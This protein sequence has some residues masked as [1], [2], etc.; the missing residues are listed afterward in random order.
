M[1]IVF[2]FATQLLLFVHQ[3]VLLRSL[4]LFRHRVCLPFLFPFVSLLSFPTILCVM[5]L[6]CFHFSFPF[7]CMMRL[8]ES[9]KLCD[10][11]MV[12]RLVMSATSRFLAQG[13]IRCFA[14][15]ATMQDPQIDGAVF[16]VLKRR[17]MYHAHIYACTSQLSVPVDR[18]TCQCQCALAH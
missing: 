5:C 8:L 4:F 7:W 15:S 18:H 9:N 13:L 12:M 3:H 6:S 10:H 16:V 11:T 1:A 14:L 17:E 2:R